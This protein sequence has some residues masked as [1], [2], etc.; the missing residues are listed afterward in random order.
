MSFTHR[1]IALTFQLGTGAYGQDGYNEIRFTGLRT[2][3]AITKAGGVSMSQL[4]LRV[5]GLPLEVMNKLTVLNQQLDQNRHNVVIVEAGDDDAGLAVVF[6]G[7]MVE[8]WADFSGIPDVSFVVK[9]S[10]AYTDALRPVVPS[11]FKG[12]VDVALLISGIAAQMIPPR[13]LENSGVSITLRNP[14]LPGTLIAQLRA[15]QQQGDFYMIIE[16]DVIAIWPKDGVRRGLVPLIS[17]ATGM[18]GS[19]SFTSTGISVTTLFNPSIVFG[20]AVQVESITRSAGVWTPF[21]VGHD[22]EAEMPAGK[23]FTHM[24]ASIFGQALPVASNG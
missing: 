12:S 11:S 10:T 22:L 20:G 24:E 6:A 7:T 15:L 21:A 23:W 13:T 9:A 19:P 2:S 3:A 18:V 17:A 1:R 8:A 16:P 5:W 4:D 14:Y